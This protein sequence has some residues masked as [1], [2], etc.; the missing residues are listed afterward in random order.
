VELRDGLTLDDTVITGPYRSLD[1][2]KDGKKVAL[3]DKDKKKPES[4]AKTEDE[5]KTAGND[6]KKDDDPKKES[7]DQPAT[8]TASVSP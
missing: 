5:A 7:K 4:D 1:Q 6:E 3:S 8:T 2:L